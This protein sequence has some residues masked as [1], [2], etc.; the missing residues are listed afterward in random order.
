MSKL[1]SLHSSS[2]HADLGPN[3]DSE[4]RESLK[5]ISTIFKWISKIFSLNILNW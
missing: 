4:S 3:I 5:V 1:Y 2:V